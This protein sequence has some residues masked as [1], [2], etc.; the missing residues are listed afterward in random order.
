MNRI[1]KIILIAFVVISCLLISF[2]V[3]AT[4][5]N[6]VSE[7]DVI[8]SFEM[9]YS[10]NNTNVINEIDKMIAKYEEMTYS[11]DE[12]ICAKSMDIVETLLE[13]RGKSI[14]YYSDNNSLNN[15][16]DLS[17]IVISLAITYFESIDCYL[18]AELLA[19]AYSNTT[20]Y[21]VYNPIHGNIVSD[22]LAVQT[23]ADDLTKIT[24]SHQFV[25]TNNDEV[26][27]D[28]YYS[29]KWCQY[30]KIYYDIDEIAFHLRD[31]YDFEQQDNM[32]DSLLNLAVGTMYSYQQQGILTQFITDISVIVDGVVPFSYTISNGYATIDSV[33]NYVTALTIPTTILDLSTYVDNTQSNSATINSIGSFAAS[34]CTNLT[35]VTFPSTLI[36]IGSCAFSDCYNLL[37]ILIPNTVTSIGQYAFESCISLNNVTISSS[38]VSISIGTF[39]FCTDLTNIIIP[40]SVTNIGNDSFY[41]CSNL[42]L[43]EVERAQVELT[44]LGSN[45]FYGCSSSLQIK[46]PNDR[47]ADYKNMT[48]WSTYSNKIIPYTNDFTTI[49]MTSSTN[50]T[51]TLTLDAG[52]NK[53]YKL[54]VV[55]QGTYDVRASISAN[56]TIKLYDSNYNLLETKSKL[57]TKTLSTGIYYV[58]IAYQSNTQSGTLYPLF[59]VHSGHSYDDH[60]QWTSLTNHKSYCSCGNYI[61]DFHIVSPDAYQNGNQYAICLL[62]NGFASVG[63]TWHDGIGNYPYTLNGSFILPNGV[64]VLEEADMEAYLNGT[65]VFINPNENIDRVNNHI[66]CII[67]R[68]DKYILD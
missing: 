55:D 31:C 50:N 7:E 14:D 54:N 26:S 3:D 32:Y 66:P 52:Y 12:S 13:L 59:K 65:L 6:N 10:S 56:T 45:S 46:V 25:I 64:I 40:S 5:S 39:K 47:I 57:L 2:K 42:S 30:E 16:R 11:E 17:D 22:S 60:Y 37:A 24:G 43:V 36:S 19:H 61:N 9:Y 33:S 48:N 53:L 63:G 62:C 28:L 58:S 68:E 18:S 1:K 51:Q 21:S 49:N 34:F 29:I 20:M 4:D 23:I 41:G 44:T 15:T 8:D 35:S 38:L 27:K 67:R